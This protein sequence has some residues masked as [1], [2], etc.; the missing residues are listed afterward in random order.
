VTNE[1]FK[2]ALD[3]FKFYLKPALFT[4]LSENADAFSEETKK[5][6]I[7]K[8][9]E[10]DSQMK[11]LVDYQEKRNSIMRSGLEKIQDLYTRAKARFQEAITGEHQT[12]VTAAD[13]LI[14][15]L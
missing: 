14:T 1:E 3:G 13:E 2:S 5:E 11:E 15:N 6:I 8:L 7:E 4:V 9:Q 10:A 12:E